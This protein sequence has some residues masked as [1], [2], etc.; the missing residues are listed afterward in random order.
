MLFCE[1]WLLVGPQAECHGWEIVAPATAGTGCTFVA[2]VC[3]S[4]GA[5]GP[6]AIQYLAVLATLELRQHEAARSLQG[7]DPLGASERA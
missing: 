4:F 2:L 7:I 5:L 3:S 1:L 6:S